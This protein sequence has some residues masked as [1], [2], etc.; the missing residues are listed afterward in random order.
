MPCDLHRRSWRLPGGT[1]RSLVRAGSDDRARQ[2][3]RRRRRRRRRHGDE[4]RDEFRGPRE[5]R[6]RDGARSST[7]STATSSACS[8]HV[9][10]TERRFYLCN[11]VD[12]KVRSDGGEVYF[13]V[14]MADAWVWDIY[15][16]ARFAKQVRVVTF[17]DV[18]VEELRQVRP[19]AAK[20]QRLLAGRC[21]HRRPRRSLG[22]CPQAGDR[23][24]R[25]G[26]PRR[27]LTACPARGA[28]GDDPAGPSGTTASGSPPATWRAGMVVLD[29]NWRC[30]PARST[31]SLRD[32]DCW[33]SARSRPA[34]SAACGAPLEA[35]TGASGAGCAGWP[36]SGVDDHAD[37]ARGSP[38]ASTPSRSC[39]RPVVGHTS[40]TYAVC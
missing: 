29:R 16:P 10:E 3:S 12:V 34:H 36:R 11:S 20:E 6:D 21:A 19:R 35:V 30:A 5:V 26:R 38:C 7:G 31:S 33:S 23:R 32:G 4:S 24:D 8:R 13:D 2:T 18:N 15:R 22:S 14:T 27:L 25:P 9:V 17:K 40:S 28:P 1:R 37:L 39:A